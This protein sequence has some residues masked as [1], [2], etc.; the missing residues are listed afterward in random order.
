MNIVAIYNAVATRLQGDTGTGGLFASTDALVTGIF[1]NYADNQL[2]FPFL[3]IDVSL[4]NDDAFAADVLNATI[5]VHTFVA[6]NSAQVDS[7]S[8]ILDRVYGNAVAQNG[9]VPT[10]GLHRHSLSLSGGW[11]AG[12]MR[13]VDMQQIPTEDGQAAFHFIQTFKVIIS[14]T[15]TSP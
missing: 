14:K 12:P 13:Q 9:R 1:N 6:L 4:E 3:V 5:I 7:Y 8:S 15:C 2:Y 11:V 10:Y